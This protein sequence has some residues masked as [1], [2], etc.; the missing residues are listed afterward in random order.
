MC[1]SFAVAGTDT[2]FHELDDL[3]GWAALVWSTRIGVGLR[4]VR[5]RVEKW[6]GSYS[7]NLLM[8]GS[9]CSKLLSSVGVCLNFYICVFLYSKISVFVYFHISIFHISL[10]V[11]LHF[12]ISIFICFLYLYVCNFNI[13]ISL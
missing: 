1:L 5:L 3:S 13:S 2:A 10:C 4:V 9:C 7:L 8:N 12:Y 11:F 6:R